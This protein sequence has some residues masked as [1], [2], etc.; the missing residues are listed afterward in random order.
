MPKKKY[1]HRDLELCG[2]TLV[3]LQA[4]IT[5]KTTKFHKRATWGI[6]VA[7]LDRDNAGRPMVGVSNDKIFDMQLDKFRYS[8]SALEII[9]SFQRLKLIDDVTA[10]NYRVRYFEERWRRD[11]QEGMDEILDVFKRNE[12]KLP[13]EAEAIIRGLLEAGAQKRRK[14]DVALVKKRKR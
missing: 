8:N 1:L 4:G 7:V 2:V 12:A 13:K 6:T 5:Y 3:P 11:V 9:D 10:A 14:K